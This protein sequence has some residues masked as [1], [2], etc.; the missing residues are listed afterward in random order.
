M[1]AT[2]NTPSK[3]SAALLSVFSGA[4]LT[5]GKLVVGVLTGSL[6]ILSDGLHSFLDLTAS[7][8]TLFT[9]RFADQPADREHPYGHARA[10]NLGALA[11]TMLLCITG[12]IIISE[13]FR[14]I[15][16]RPEVPE[17]TIWSFVIMAVSIVVDANR[18]STLRKAAR[19]HASPALEADAANFANDML[20]SSLVLVALV[21]M[22]FGP[23]WGIPAG[24]ID[25][26]DGA[27]GAIVALFAFRVAFTLARRSADSLMDTVPRE[28][29]EDFER[30]VQAVPD[31]LPEGTRVRSRFIGQKPYVEVTLS[32]AH[33]AT[34]EAANAVA[35]H[36]EEA[37]HGVEP[38]ADVIVDVRPARPRLERHEAAVRAAAFR[39]GLEVHN[40]DILILEDGLHAHLDLELPPH[41]GLRTAHGRSEELEAEIKNALPD[42]KRVW[43]HLEPRRLQ[44]RPAVRDAITAAKVRAYLTDTAGE[45]V[46]DLEAMM[47]D[48]GSVVH[49]SLGFDAEAPLAVVHEHMAQLERRLRLNV[50]GLAEVHLDP[51]VTINSAPSITPAA[52]SGRA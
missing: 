14:K 32:V 22:R 27:T 48:E 30:V 7:S 38:L 25:R 31:V 3:D 35:R 33:G 41:L 13:A 17:V 52:V 24:V 23:G 49:I 16:V 44:E 45:R 11:E 1:S 26:L 51:D 47:T 29:S 15:F 36:V 46:T 2:H 28:L 19:A 21:V 50:P 18:V 37:I 12:T 4:I 9:V 42:L 40:L 10:E 43:I 20:A 5:I 34:L 6:S 8:V 39:L